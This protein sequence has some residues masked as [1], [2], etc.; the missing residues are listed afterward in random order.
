MQLSCDACQSRYKIADARVAGRV[1]RIRC[2]KCGAILVASGVPAEEPAATEPSPRS[3]LRTGERN[4]QSVLFSLSALQ[5]THAHAPPPAHRQPP[6]LPTDGSGLVDLRSLMP[7]VASRAARPD[8]AEAIAHLGLGG[9]FAPELFVAEPTPSAFMS[10]TIERPAGRRSLVVAVVGGALAFGIASTALAWALARRP[11]PSPAASVVLAPSPAPATPETRP[12]ESTAVATRHEEPAPDPVVRALPLAPSRPAPAHPSSAPVASAVAATPDAVP[13]CCPG[14]TDTACA[15]RREVGVDCGASAS[16]AS[17][18]PPPF[19]SAA[20][21]RALASV[22]LRGCASGSATPGHA[23]ITFQ[24]G[25]SVSDVV[26]DAPSTPGAATERCV[27]AAY[28]RAKIL[29]FS[30][31]AVTVGKRFVLGAP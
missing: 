23:R 18:A 20:A 3:S 11:P 25:G 21:S 22:D 7:S 29:A 28:R 27:G 6:T 1:V 14:E 31:P 10:R 2:R 17:A 9:V 8:P 15:I 26:V 5:E 19:D 16:P 30:G 24:P 13:R 12:I 4:E